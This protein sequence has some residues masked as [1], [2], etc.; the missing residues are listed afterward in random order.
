MACPFR[1]TLSIWER[2]KLHLALRWLLSR[3]HPSR[4]SHTS[5]SCPVGFQSNFQLFLSPTFNFLLVL[6]Y[7]PCKPPLI[8]YSFINIVIVI[9]SID[10]EYSFKQSNKALDKSKLGKSTSVTFLAFHKVSRFSHRPC[11]LARLL[12]KSLSIAQFKLLSLFDQPFV[13]LT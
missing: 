8:K 5:F 7:R 11:E 10:S 2:V 1:W 9:I 13:K 6:I 4:G 12:F 3:L